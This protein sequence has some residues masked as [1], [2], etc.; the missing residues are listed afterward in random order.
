MFTKIALI[1]NGSFALCLKPGQL[2][3]PMGLAQLKAYLQQQNFQVQNLLLTNKL[4]ADSSERNLLADFFV[5]NYVSNLEK[6]QRQDINQKIVA[7][8]KKQ[9]QQEFAPDL[10]IVGLSLMCFE[11]VLP[12]LYTALALKELNSQIIIVLGG[13]YLNLVNEEI[14]ADN[15]NLLDFL[16]IGDGEKPLAEILRQAAD[17]N[18]LLAVPGLQF[19]YQ[20]KVHSLPAQYLSLEEMV[21]PD[22]DQENNQPQIYYNFSRGCA[23]QCI[24]C[25]LKDKLRF[26]NIEQIKSELAELLKRY[27]PAR[28]FFIDA[29]A[30][31]NW[32][33]LLEVLDYLEILPVDFALALW[34]DFNNFP[35][36]LIAGIKK[37]CQRKRLAVKF[38]LESGSV[39]MRN[40]LHK[41]KFS[42][43][44]VIDILQ[45]LNTAGPNLQIHINVIASIPYEKEEYFAQTLNL[46]EQVK[47]LVTSVGVTV[48]QLTP[49]SLLWQNLDQYG[50]KL[51]E[52]SLN[53]YNFHYDYEEVAGLGQNEIR[54]RDQL[55]FQ[56]LAE[57]LAKNNLG[58]DK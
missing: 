43:E 14:L 55:Y 22:Y 40:Y 1:Y 54:L 53:K 33:L 37:Y 34:L 57:F 18:K 51:G 42:N 49:F 52:K 16:V 28:L 44:Q 2:S 19:I 31:N 23:G 50:L 17:K 21:L 35:K 3:L 47:T 45:Q 39:E 7:I 5:T 27:Q 25:C 29:S 56:R 15:K 4:M 24:F 46:I 12:T 20:D 8:I 38:G 11:D 30:N 26:K 6:W 32:P 13:A 58:Y 36:Q 10:A 41:P 9:L 48:F